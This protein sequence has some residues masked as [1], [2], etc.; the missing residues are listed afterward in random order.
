MS[1]ERR[2]ML[3]MIAFVVLWTLVELV[4][5]RL[6]AAYTAYQVVWMRYGVH[7]ALMWAWWG[8]REPASL[9]RTRRPGFQ[10]ARSALMFV[11]PISWFLGTQAGVPIGTTMAL[12]WLAPLMTLAAAAFW[13]REPAGARTWAVAL[14]AAT[15]AA[16]F[17][18]PLKLPERNWL[19]LAPMAM[20]LSFALYLVMTRSLRTEPRRANL[21]YTALGVFV[22][23]TPVQPFIW[24]TPGW[25]DLARFVAVGVIGYLTLLVLDRLAAAAP[26]SVTAPACFLQLALSIGLGLAL[27]HFAFDG[28]NLAALALTC[29][30][31]ALLF[32]ARPA[33]QVRQEPA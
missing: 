31:L 3:L 17:Y 21:F 14:V 12:F 6:V 22:L 7:L 24:V 28:A 18:L 2:G 29:A 4:A 9:V 23:L 13:L 16:L 8:W 30:P 15:G 11:M 5:A 32:A 20:G 10:L 27:G 19:L 33:A 1:A 26:W 25:G